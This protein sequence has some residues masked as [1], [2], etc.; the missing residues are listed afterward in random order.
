M[1]L[2]I[3]ESVPEEEISDQIWFNCKL[4]GEQNVCVL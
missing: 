4:I 1:W 2:V 3:F